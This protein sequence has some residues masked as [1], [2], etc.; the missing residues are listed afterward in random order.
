MLNV[1]RSVHTVRKI[2]T[3]G[4]KSWWNVVRNVTLENAIQV[5]P[6]SK[7]T[8]RKFLRKADWAEPAD[9]GKNHTVSDTG[10]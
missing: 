6:T 10:H 3:R 9:P 7:F 1:R 2:G 8:D 5:I 4:P